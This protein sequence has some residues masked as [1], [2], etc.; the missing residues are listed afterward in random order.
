MQCWDLNPWPCTCQAITLTTETCPLHL[1][2]S[3]FVLFNTIQ[4]WKKLQQ[5]EEI[6]TSFCEEHIYSV[7]WLQLFP[8]PLPRTSGRLFFVDLNM[9][10][11]SSITNPHGVLP[12]L[13]ES[14]IFAM[15]VSECCSVSQAMELQ[16]W[17]LTT[18]LLISWELSVSWSLEWDCSLG[19]Q[20]LLLLWDLGTAPS[21]TTCTTVWTMAA[22][23]SLTFYPQDLS[24]PHSPNFVYFIN[25]YNQKGFLNHH[26]I[27]A[28]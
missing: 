7:T 10:I 6:S 4:Q 16:S 26:S 28:L 14:S 9:R 2:S 3:S 11:T 13:L 18:V 12:F 25:S 8:P 22:G 1:L 23:F 5:E 21:R 19:I 17:V 27:F 15:P 24:G 20:L